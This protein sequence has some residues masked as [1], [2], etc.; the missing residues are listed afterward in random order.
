MYICMYQRNVYLKK[1]SVK[2]LHKSYLYNILLFQS[3]IYKCI[4]NQIQSYIK[5]M[6]KKTS[7][8]FTIQ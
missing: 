7:T 8:K 4:I 5:L 6:Q 2:K 1:K 3:E